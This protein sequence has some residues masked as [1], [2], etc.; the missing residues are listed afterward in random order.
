[1]ARYT[2][3]VTKVTEYE[4]EAL[5][6]E[7]A[8]D[9]IRTASAFADGPGY[10]VPQVIDEITKGVE[11]LEIDERMVVQVVFSK[12]GNRYAYAVPDS[13]GVRIGDM[14]VTPNGFSNRRGVAEVVDV[15]RGGYAGPLKALVGKVVTED[16][17]IDPAWD[18]QVGDDLNEDAGVVF[19]DFRESREDKGLGTCP[20]CGYA[21]KSA[22]ASTP[23]RGAMS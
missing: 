18:T 9:A 5:T 8:E 7:Y 1:M 11:V 13:L 2:V 15:G 12:N 20:D 19:E 14:V 22:E 4:V 17:E 16:A 3:L 6:A 23:C 10:G 21:Y